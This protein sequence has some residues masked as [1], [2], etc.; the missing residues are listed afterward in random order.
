MLPHELVAAIYD[1]CPGLFSYLFTGVPG[2]LERYWGYNSDLAA[3]LEMTPSES[4]PKFNVFF[5]DVPSNL[6]VFFHW[7]IIRAL[8]T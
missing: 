7:E 1:Y 2:A 8:F 4:L 6:W 5:K 3:D